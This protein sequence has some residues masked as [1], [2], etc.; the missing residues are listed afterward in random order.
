MC[1]SSASGCA[2]G[3]GVC[4]ADHPAAPRGY[5]RLP[6]VST[7][8]ARAVTNCRCDRRI[9][10]TAAPAPM[11]VSTQSPLQRIVPSTIELSSRPRD[12]QR[13]LSRRK[14][15]WSRRSVRRQRHAAWSANVSGT[16]RSG[17]LASRGGHL[18]TSSTT[19][20]VKCQHIDRRQSA[21]SA[22]SDEVL[23]VTRN[24]LRTPVRGGVRFEGPPARRAGRCR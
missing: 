7:L 2:C 9:I 12:A 11:N 24:E 16:G 8:R 13:I 6:L 3:S 17:R 22:L 20:G 23:A 21:G 1:S 14:L 10:K 15:A 19:A 4:D 5:A 18:V